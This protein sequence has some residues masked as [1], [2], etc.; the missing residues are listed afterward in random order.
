MVW[1]T[2]CCLMLGAASQLAEPKRELPLT[3]QGRMYTARLVEGRTTKSQKNLL[4]FTLQLV[5]EDQAGQRLLESA[6]LPAGGGLV[7]QPW[8]GALFGYDQEILGLKR[9]DLTSDGQPEVV[10]QF[11]GNEADAHELFIVSLTGSAPKLLFDSSAVSAPSPTR[12][13][14]RNFILKAK[15]K[16][17]WVE[18]EF[19]RSDGSKVSTVVRKYRYDP[20]QDRFVMLARAKARVNSL[21]SSI[22]TKTEE[23][24]TVDG[25]DF[26]LDATL[27]DVALD[28]PDG[29]S[30]PVVTDDEANVAVCTLTTGW[31]AVPDKDITWCRLP[32][33]LGNPLEA[34]TPIILVITHYAFCRS[35]VADRYSGVL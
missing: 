14:G 5:I 17:R 1:T 25:E 30:R 23:L 19:V 35:F 13:W 26:L 34:S 10:A 15:G 24:R 4:G 28:G 8:D 33:P 20:K 16:E 27:T 22:A 7:D 3:V 18:G 32:T 9:L 2:I 11:Q 29:T 12:D 6:K 21:S 31:T